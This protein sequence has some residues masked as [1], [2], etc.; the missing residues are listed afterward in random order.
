MSNYEKIYSVELEGEEYG[1]FLSKQ[2]SNKWWIIIPDC[3]GMADM[4][5]KY[6]QQCEWLK[7][8]IFKIPGVKE[9]W[10]TIWEIDNNE[11]MEQVENLFLKYGKISNK[12]S[13]D[14]Y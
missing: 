9:I 6:P 11:V 13:I 14:F 5:P 4:L 12:T 8:K 2:E 1:F 10:G 7:S 3:G